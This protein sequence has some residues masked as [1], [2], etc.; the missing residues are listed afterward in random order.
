M[1]LKY[2]LKFV[3]I[4]F[5]VITTAQVLFISTVS[6]ITGSET[7]MTSWDMLKLP[8]V[9][10]ASVLPTLMYVR[11]NTKKLPGRAEAIILQIL[12]FTLTS[13]IVFGLLIYFGYMGAAN[14]AFIIALF[15]V[16]YV[17]ACV[18][19]ERRD[20]KLANKLNERINAIH[21]TDNATRR[22]KP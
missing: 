2:A 21:N 13:G 1:K 11:R 14:A 15:I 16:I 6:I 20:R 18:I 12:H 5:C 8:L 22:D 4:L 7:L 9:A 17:P 3:F 19:Q 10:F